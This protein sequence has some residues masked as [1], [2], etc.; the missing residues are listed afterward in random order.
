[1][2]PTSGSL[3]GANGWPED[4]ARESTIG[5]I[6]R[7]VPRLNGRRPPPFCCCRAC[8]AAIRCPS[9][10]IVRFPP[11]DC[12]L[13]NPGRFP[14]A[15]TRVKKLVFVQLLD[16]LFCDAGKTVHPLAVLFKL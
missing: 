15:L 11:F 5:L 9:T 1:M 13:Q 14:F 4:Q 12:E 8:C 10:A 7:S 6:R 2:N 16:S 3:T